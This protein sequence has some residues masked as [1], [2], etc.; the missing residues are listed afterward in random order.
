MTSLS[1]RAPTLHRVSD[2]DV[3][4]SILASTAALLDGVRDEQLTLPTPCA[5]FDVRALRD[6]ILRGGTMFA[7]AASGAAGGDF[8]ADAALM[9]RGWREQ[10]TD[11]SVTVGVGEVPATVAVGMSIVEFCTHGCDLA[12]ATGQEIPYTDDELGRALAVAQA[13]VP[14]D[15]RG[16]GKAFG[17]VVD[18]DDTATSAHRLLGFMGRQVPA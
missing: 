14:D 1:V 9:V 15:F 3:L 12:L 11:R 6:H 13:S 10:G 2:I 4:D 5:E 18:V 7:V 17:Q 8:R 16:P